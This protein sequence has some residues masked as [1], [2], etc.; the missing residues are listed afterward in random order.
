MHIL[1][2]NDHKSVEEVLSNFP[3]CAIIIE[4]IQGVGGLD[5]P[6]SEFLQQL[7]ALCKSHGALLIADEVQSGYGRSGSFLPFNNIP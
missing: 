4:P 7:E 1:P 3:V 6:T 5:E 2:L